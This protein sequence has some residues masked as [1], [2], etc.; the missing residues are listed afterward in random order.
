MPYCCMPPDLVA[1]I[2]GTWGGSEV[3][4]TSAEIDACCIY[5]HSSPRFDMEELRRSFC[6]ITNWETLRDTAPPAPLWRLV[7]GNVRD[8]ARNISCQQDFAADGAFSLGM[9]ARFEPII[10]E[11]ASAW[12]ELFWEAGMIG[13]SLYLAAEADGMRGTG[14]GCYCGNGDQWPRYS[15]RRPMATLWVKI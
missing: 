6:T 4:V 1:K 13:Q 12:R 14:I 15:L 3:V 10:R 9:L 2:S 7:R 5:R 11:R 8:F